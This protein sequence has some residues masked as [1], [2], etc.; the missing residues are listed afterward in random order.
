ML[1]PTAVSIE[2]HPPGP[3][4]VLVAGPVVEVA[5]AGG[6]TGLFAVRAHG[7]LFRVTVRQTDASGVPHRIE[8]GC[9]L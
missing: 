9:S 5:P 1:V 2:A 7:R 6:P 8:Q 4:D 3:K